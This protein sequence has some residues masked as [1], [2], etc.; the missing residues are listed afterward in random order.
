VTTPDVSHPTPSPSA[1]GAGRAE[2]PAPSVPP[3][4]SQGPDAAGGLAA[5]SL[6]TRRAIHRASRTWV[7]LAAGL[8][9][10]VLVL[11]FILQNLHSARAH[12]FTADW[13]IPLGVDLLLAAVLGGLIVFTAGS[14]RILQL[15]RAAHR[16]GRRASRRTK[17]GAGS[18]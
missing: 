10:T 7:T 3:P 2:G 13:S 8:V 17:E 1:G 6:H 14:I 9:A 4:A 18:S 5:Q 11:V 16:D 12:F 15:R